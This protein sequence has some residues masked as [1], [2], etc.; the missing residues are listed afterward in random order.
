MRLLWHTSI[1]QLQSR[2]RRRTIDILVH[3]NIGSGVTTASMLAR[4]T[5]EA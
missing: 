1:K 5:Q 3:T 2:R 4:V